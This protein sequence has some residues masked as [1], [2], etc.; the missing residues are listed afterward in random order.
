MVNR[1]RGTWPL[2]ALLAVLATLVAACARRVP[3][4]P[5]Y[6]AEIEA[7]RAHRLASLKAENG[8]LSVVGLFWLKP[9]ENRFGSAAANEIV[10]PGPGTPGVAG[11][12]ELRPD[13][14]VLAH[15]APGAGVVLDGSPAGERSLRSD[16][17][18][19][20]PD[21]LRIGTVSLYLIDRSGK[22][23]VRAKDSRN[24]ARTGFKGIES[25]PVDPSYRVLGTFEAYP[26]ARRVAVATAQGPNQTMLVPGIVRFSLAG[27][28][29]A[30]EPFVNSPDDDT[31]FFVL[32]DGTSGHETYGASRF[33]DAAAPT[34]G[35]RSVVLDFNKATNPPC[36][37]TPFA[38]C[39]LPLPG[40]VLKVRIKAGEKYSGSE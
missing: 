24:P 32:R 27:R 29:L 8:W 20:K 25:F 21:V 33:L 40:N 36:A 30:L 17:E 35:S 37:F 14:T 18:G 10:L 5:A 15:P 39:P 28:A 3:P 11:T 26:E 34:K 38:T 13:G 1:F 22:L 6:L 2:A 9:G 12:L 19:G 7:W 23:A 4:D 16:R 31:F